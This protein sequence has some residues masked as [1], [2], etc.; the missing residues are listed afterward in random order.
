MKNNDNNYELT[1]RLVNYGDCLPEDR[2]VV[3]QKVTNLSRERGMELFESHKA[4]KVDGQLERLQQLQNLGFNIIICPDCGA[5]TIAYLEEE[6]HVCYD[7]GLE[8]K[9][10]D[11]PDLHH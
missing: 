1:I 2:W 10:F 3:M 11:A 9:P 8:Y 4:K 6:D 5:V 7:C